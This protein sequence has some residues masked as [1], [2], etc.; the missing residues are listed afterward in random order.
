ML[1]KSSGNSVGLPY[2]F[3]ILSRKGREDEN[4]FLVPNQSGCPTAPINDDVLAI[5]RS[6]LSNPMTGI[7]YEKLLV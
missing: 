4:L 6:P 2:I 1:A 7:R 3:M 5:C